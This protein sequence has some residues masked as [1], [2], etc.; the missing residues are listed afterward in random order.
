MI[1]C[2]DDPLKVVHAV[3][4]LERLA[5]DAG[6]FVFVKTDF[7]EFVEIRDFVRPDETVSAMFDPAGTQDLSNGTRAF[8]VHGVDRQGQT[9][10]L[11]AARIDVVDSNLAQWAMLWMSGLY[12]MRGDSVEPARWQALQHSAA[13]RISGDVV[14]HGEFWLSSEF[15]GG[16][17]GNMLD[18]LPRMAL[19]LI[20]LKWQPDHVWGLVTEKLGSR[21]IP[22]RMGYSVQQP[23][24]LAWHSAPDGAS[25]EE[26]FAW[27][28]AEDLA[29]LAELE[30]SRA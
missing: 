3:A 13:E 19:L 27:C 12:R 16:D 20:S 18:V 4:R 23:A 22:F 14:Y 24:M 2:L 29:Y 17:N 7:Q 25:N 10:S 1:R 30:S 5:E 21:G 26:T 15:R 9:V 8:W 6:I 28:S 11:Q